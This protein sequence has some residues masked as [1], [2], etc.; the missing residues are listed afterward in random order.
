MMQ[1]EGVPEER[2]ELFS[3]RLLLWQWKSVKQ[4]DMSNEYLAADRLASAALK[5]FGHLYIFKI[6]RLINHL[7]ENDLH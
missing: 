3:Q 1:N 7:I 5:D 6:K 2:L 4:T